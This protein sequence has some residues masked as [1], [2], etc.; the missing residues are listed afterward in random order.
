MNVTVPPASETSAFGPREVM[1]AYHK[2]S[3]HSLQRY[4]TGPETLDWDLQ[5]NPF[6]EFSGSPR[7]GLPLRAKGLAVPYCDARVPGAVA[8]APLG[9]ESVA[10]LLELAMGLSA[11]KEFGPDRWA[12]RCNPS[13]GNLHPT[14]AY[15]VAEGVPG[16]AGGLHHYVSRD[17]V[18]ELR[19]SSSATPA[20]GRLLVGLT[21]IQWREAWKYGERAF[22]YCQLD[23]GHALGALR[24]AAGVLGWTVRLVEGVPSAAIGALLGVDRAEDFTG[25]EREDPELLLEVITRPAADGSVAAPLPLPV[26]DG[27][28]TG[29]ANVLDRH[30]MYRWPIIDEVSVATHGGSAGAGANETGSYPPLNETSQASASAVILGRRSAQRFTGKVNMTREVFLGLMDSLLVRPAAPFDVWNFGP[31]IHPVLF[32]HHVEE[33][34]P[35]LYALPRRPEAEAMLRASLRD[36]FLWQKPEGCPEHLPLFCLVPTDSRAMARTLSCHQHI[37]SDSAF[38]LGMLSE[39]EDT[40]TADPWRYRQLYWEA[41][42]VGQAL[43]LEAEAAGVR[44]TGIGCYFDDDLH[45]LL[46]IEGLKFQSLYHFTVGFPLTD[47]RIATTPA[48]PGRED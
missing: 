29:A 11:W 22:R 43:Y 3:K 12:L 41:G 24:Y 40:V 44:G 26:L 14:E 47:A 32:V 9:L 36:D 7:T 15:V 45:Q 2:R 25:A 38:A 16:L 1:L 37:A 20:E 4:A 19:R 42:L 34:T 39:F 8:P 10:L 5:P 30:P 35:G 6:R 18:L 33:L 21:S 28:W 17:H 13:S 23:V 27:P 31:R 46:G 48:Y